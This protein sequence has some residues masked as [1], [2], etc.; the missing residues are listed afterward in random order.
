MKNVR[1]FIFLSLISSLISSC[2]SDEAFSYKSEFEISKDAW[3]NFKKSSDN[4]YKYTVINSSWT[5]FS[6]ETTI[7]VQKGVI[8]NRSFKYISTGGESNNIPQSELQW[9]EEASEIGTHKNGAKPITL[10]EVYD[11]A[12]QTWLSNKGDVKIYFEAKNNGMISLC[13]YVENGCADDCFTGVNINS[14]V[15]I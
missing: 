15:A 2:S 4:T 7:T 9:V 5:G 8:T 10:D 14:I 12:E 3:L 11:L 1:L 6:W 13:G